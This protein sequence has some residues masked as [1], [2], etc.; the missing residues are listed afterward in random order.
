VEHRIE[1]DGIRFDLLQERL[2]A[3]HVRES[4]DLDGARARPLLHAHQRLRLRHEA[5]RDV[6]TE[7]RG[8]AVGEIPVGHLIDTL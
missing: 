1:F 3:L 4:G 7:Y 6:T 2:D 5:H 8:L